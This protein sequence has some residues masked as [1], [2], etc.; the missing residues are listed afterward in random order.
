[1]SA[2]SVV[3]VF[4]AARFR[5]AL[6]L[7][8]SAGNV[9][10]T[11]PDAVVAVQVSL[12]DSPDAELGKPVLV[13]AEL[14]FAVSREIGEAALLLRRGERDEDGPILRLLPGGVS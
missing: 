2:P 5:S 6:E 9:A 3:P 12:P 11:E 4:E 7:L 13:S 14:L 10:C 8:G 1:M